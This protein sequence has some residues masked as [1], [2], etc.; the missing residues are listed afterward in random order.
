MLHT[1]VGMVRV[2]ADGLVKDVGD[3]DVVRGY[4]VSGRLHLSD[5]Q[6]I[7]VGTPVMLTRHGANDTM[8]AAVDK[9]AAFTFESVPPETVSL[10]VRLKG[11]RLSEKSHSQHCTSG[12]SVEARIDG[13]LNGVEILL[14]PQ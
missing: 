11:Y 9:T 3:L 1:R 12:W 2:G 7:P 13:D 14:E 8:T 10:W 4:R 5:N 6:P